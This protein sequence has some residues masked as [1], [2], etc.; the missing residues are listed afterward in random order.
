MIVLVFLV[1]LN[2][3]DAITV[4]VCSSGC[5]YTTIQAAVYNASNGDVINV[6]SGAYTENVTIN[7]SV[8]LNATPYIS[9][10]GG[11][12]ITES[13]VTITGFNITS[14]IALG[15]SGR[16]GT[17]RIGIL[18]ESGNNSITKNILNNITGENG[19][20]SSDDSTGG[21][22]GIG[23]A[24]YLSI[25]A[26]NNVITNTISQ[27][28]GG[29][30]G[31]G[32]ELG[33]GGNGGIGTAIYLSSSTNNNITNNTISQIYGGTAGNGGSGGAGGSGGIGG[34]I[35]LSDSSNNNLS[36]NNFTDIIGG[37][38]GDGG[39]GGASGSNQIGVGIYIGSGSYNNKIDTTNTVDGDKIFYYFNKTGITIRDNILIK[40]S[41]PTNLGKI[42]LINSS[43]FLI[44][45]NTI[46]NF[47]GESGNTRGEDVDG[48]NGGIGVGIYL[49]NSS[50]LN[51]S[52]NTIIQ[53]YGG[54]GGSGGDS[55]KGGN[56]GISSGIYLDN[57][58]NINLS[59]NTINNITFNIFRS[60]HT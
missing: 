54:K 42:V 16:T 33:S 32:G 53:I 38:G 9:L 31:N 19:D 43:N 46:A 5:N 45:N 55:G 1:R 48:F 30:A 35:Y 52:Q 25:S 13:N 3:I 7:V 6:S 39:A 22:G 8:F 28:Y 23:A 4:S 15:Q 60:C 57:S 51:I 24:I 17:Y 11:F 21:D 10:T 34:G 40:N 37:I 12:N 49:I 56:G 50:N 20:D 41:S 2:L 27:I 26:S 47:T 58:I 29:T 59:T 14:G 18:I 44:T 36:L